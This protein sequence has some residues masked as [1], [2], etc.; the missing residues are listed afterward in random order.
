MKKF[1]SILFATVLATAALADEET[2]IDRDNSRLSVF[3]QPAI[4]FRE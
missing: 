1:L 2:K 4:S 3:V